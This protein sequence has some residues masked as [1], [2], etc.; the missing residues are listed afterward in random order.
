MS[1][2]ILQQRLE[3]Y[4][5]T[6]RQEEEFAVK[7][8]FQEILLSALSRTDFFKKAAFQGG[9]ALRVLYRLNRFSED[10][11]FT[12]K[13]PDSHFEIQSYAS[14]IINEF[15]I[16][17]ISVDFQNRTKKNEMV[18][19]LFFKQESMPLPLKARHAPKNGKAKQI[20]IKLEVD[21][22]PPSGSR[23]ETKYH[24]FPIAFSLTI[25]DLPS[26]FAGKSHALLCREYAKGRDWYDFLWY[27]A[28]RTPINFEFLSRA[29]EQQGSWKGESLQINQEWYLREMRKKIQSIDWNAAKLEV[30]RFLRGRSL[31]TLEIWGQNFFLDRLDQLNQ[32]LGDSSVPAKREN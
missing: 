8:I 23:Y 3:Q 12:L 31:Q 10:L 13:K 30:S 18:Q 27:V 25:Q 28:G 29:C 11:D 26:L 1:L 19:K 22:N 20:R 2:P 15:Q 7:E 4:Q 9:T 16:Y 17:G 6:S 24:D 5:C 21:S 14:T 32:Y